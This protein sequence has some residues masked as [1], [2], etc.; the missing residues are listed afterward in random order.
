[1]KKPITM[2]RPIFG[3][4][5]KKNLRLMRK[6]SLITRKMLTRNSLPNFNHKYRRT[7]RRPTIKNSL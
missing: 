6:R 7:R 2:N 5:K 1:M 4:K 3:K